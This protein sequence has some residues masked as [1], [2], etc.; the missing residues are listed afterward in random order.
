MKQ[1]H[2]ECRTRKLGFVLRSPCW[3]R[4]PFYQ[5]LQR[6]PVANAILVGGVEGEVFFRKRP[7]LFAEGLIKFSSSRK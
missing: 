4:G 2:G 3:I 6:L 1:R 5:T 7:Q